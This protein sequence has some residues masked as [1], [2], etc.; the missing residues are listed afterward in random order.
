MRINMRQALLFTIAIAFLLSALAKERAAQVQNTA[1]L[2]D[3]LTGIWNRHG[4]IA[5]NNRLLQTSG[6]DCEVA[7]VL[8]IHVDNFNAIS[9]GWGHLLGHRALEILATTVKAVIRSSDLVGR[10]DDDKF[11]V[12][13]YGA[14]RERALAIA[15]RIKSAFAE[16]AA[17]IAGQPVGATLSIGLVPHEGPMAALTELLWM[18]HRALSRANESGRNRI[19][20]LD[21]SQFLRREEATAC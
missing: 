12:V 3:P 19:E 18:A 10:L 17:V 6:R 9:E 7:A 2:L 5:E 14:Q 1:P 4:F 11:A 20:M 15:E 8:L 13:L 21:P 16:Q